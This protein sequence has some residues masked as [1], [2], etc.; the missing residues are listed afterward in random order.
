MPA[1]IAAEVFEM[2]GFGSEVWNSGVDRPSRAARQPCK[3]VT[4]TCL[5]RSFQHQPQPLLDQIPKLTA[6]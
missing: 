5:R 6:A 4:P 3:T 2:L 1:V